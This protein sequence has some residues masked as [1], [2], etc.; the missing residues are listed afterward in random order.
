MLKNI[1]PVMTSKRS[2]MGKRL[3]V[4][5]ASVQ[6]R[7][8]EII[9]FECY[10]SCLLIAPVSVYCISITF[11]LYFSKENPENLSVWFVLF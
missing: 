4:H 6:Q 1:S 8:K 9:S 2:Q 3:M 5:C 10:P 11:V 7:V